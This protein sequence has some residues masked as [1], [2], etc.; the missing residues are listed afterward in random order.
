M[1]LRMV[2]AG[3][4]AAWEAALVQA[5][6]AG[7]VAAQVLHRCY[8]LGDLLAVAAAGQAEVA[9]VAAGTRWLDRDALARLAGAG[10]AVVGVAPAADEDSE[11]RLR[12]LGLLQVASDA[13]PPEALVERARAA[14]ASEPDPEPDLAGDPPPAEVAPAPADGG[15]RRILAAVWGPKGGP[16]RTTV[17]VNLAFE[18]AASGDEVLLVDADTYG[19]AIAQTLG[20]LDE[21][22]G[23]AWAARTAGRGELDAPRL[24]RSVRRAAP[25]GPRVLLGLPRA[26]LW[27]EIR[28]GTWEA[29]LELFRVAFPVT[30]VDAGFCLEE[31][32]E[33]LSDQVRLRRNAVTRLAV[34]AA[35]LVVAVARADPVGLHAFIRGYQE[36]RDLGIPASRVRVVV[37]QLRPGMFGGDRPAEQVR[38]ALSRYVGIDPAAV[39]PYDRPGVDAA[40]LAGQALREA[41][42]GS[43]AQIALARLAAFLFPAQ[44]VQS[45]RRRGRAGASVTAATGAGP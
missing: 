32:E 41:R 19:G 39:I 31:D 37:N 43:P 30:V 38:A 15:A 20:F 29:L 21:A 40:L 8:D 5:C 7:Q 34:Q 4:G 9:L 11:R 33:R 27:T 22:P 25:S 23:L 14:L 3:V 10:L 2:T 17:A 16:G 1:T 18:A 44:T 35:D 42:P 45:R 26:E 12:Q 28:P 36:L 13:D 24:W 6:Q